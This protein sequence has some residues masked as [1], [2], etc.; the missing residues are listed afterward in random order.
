LTSHGRH[1]GFLLKDFNSFNGAFGFKCTNGENVPES[2]HGE[3]PFRKEILLEITGL[4][5][6]GFQRRL[7]EKKGYNR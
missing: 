7:S 3:P 5:E 1:Q 2:P 4:Q 6:F